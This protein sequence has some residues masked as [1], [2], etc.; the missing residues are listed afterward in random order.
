[1]YIQVISIIMSMFIVICGFDILVMLSISGFLKNFGLDIRLCFTK[2][3][4]KLRKWSEYYGL[5]S[6][7]SL[8]CEISQV[9]FK[10]P[11]PSSPPFPQNPYLFCFPVSYSPKPEKQS[12]FYTLFFSCFFTSCQLKNYFNFLNVSDF[13][14]LF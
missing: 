7:L 5:S 8:P 13:Q 14:H 6:I 4:C 11:F 2:E 3:K 9:F 10:C 1:M 12:S